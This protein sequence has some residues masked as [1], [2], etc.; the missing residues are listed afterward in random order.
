MEAKDATLSQ[1]IEALRIFQS[2]QA[3]EP[4][5]RAGAKSMK[6]AKAETDIARLLGTVKP[7]KTTSSAPDPKTLPA[8]K[9]ETTLR[10]DMSDRQYRGVRVAQ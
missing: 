7:A 1:K 8:D 4:K 6:R 2:F 9:I 3:H 5:P 10:E